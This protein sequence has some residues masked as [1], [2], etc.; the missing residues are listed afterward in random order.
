[1][2]QAFSAQPFGFNDSD[3]RN[4]SLLAELVLGALTPEDE[5]RFAES[6]QVAATK[7][8]AASPTPETV[9]SGC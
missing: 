2:L 1:L 7:L 3:V 6:A 4:L 8:E 9:P 5:D